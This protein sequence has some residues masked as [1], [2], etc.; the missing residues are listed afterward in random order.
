MRIGATADQHG[1]IADATQLGLNAVQDL[2]EDRVVQVEDQD[3]DGPAVPVGQAARGRVGPVPELGGG[4]MIAV[5]LSVATLGESR[6]ANDTNDF[7]TPA[8]AATSWMVGRGSGRRLPAV[9]WTSATW[10]G[11]PVATDRSQAIAARRLSSADSGG[12]G[13]ALSPATRLT[14]AAVS[15]RKASRNRSTNPA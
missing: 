4:R 7:D 15:R 14:K 10:I 5:R 13:L 6:M 8:R 9:A 3:A 12:Q 11:A 1:A 2:G